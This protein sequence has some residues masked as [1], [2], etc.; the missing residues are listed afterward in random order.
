MKNKFFRLII[1]Y[2]LILSFFLPTASLGVEVSGEEVSHETSNIDSK[3]SS[4]CALLIEEKTGDILYEKNAYGK[5][6]PASTTKI[7]TAIIVLEKCYLNERVTVSSSAISA[8]PPSYTKAN[9]QP[10]EEFTVEELLNVLLIPSA[11]D[12]ANALAEHVSGSTS[13]FASL[14]NERAAELGLKGSHFTNPSGIHDENL[15]TTA[16]D[17]SIL[18]R[19]AMNIEKF[20]EIV[21]KTE[22][23]LPGTAIHPEANRTFYTSNLLL[24]PDEKNYYFPNTTGIKTGFTDSA[25]DCLVASAKKD[26]I[27]FIAVCLNGKTLNNGIREK[28]L[29]CKTLFDFAFD[30]Y[31]TYYKDLQAKQ[32]E[33]ESKKVGPEA[34]LFSQETYGTEDSSSNYPLLSFLLKVL[35]ILIIII[36]IKL[37]FF[38]KKKNRRRRFKKRH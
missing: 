34:S 29:D 19:Y 4:S 3:I 24:N 6:Y 22:Y 32:A 38:R 12:A 28:F 27:E 30:N 5:M 23:T 26:D 16:F 33:L 8:V 20:R 7:L 36:A 15:Y 18:A 14:M 9:L 25:G 31:T 21:A 13:D 2:I 11:N 1:F 10:G 17:L 37:L 35:A